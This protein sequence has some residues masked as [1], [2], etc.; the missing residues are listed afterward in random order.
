MSIIVEYSIPASKFLLGRALK[1]APDLEIEL[2]QVIPTGGSAIPYFWVLDD[3]RDQ[4]EA[5]LDREPG[6]SEYEAVD[7]LDDQTLYRAEWD[8]TADTFVRVI[9]DHDV[10]LQQSSGDADSWEFQ[11]RFPDAETLSSFR[12]AYRE[13][14]VDATVE[15]LYHSAE[16]SDSLAPLTE[17]QRT[18]LE[19]AYEAGYFEVPRQITLDELASRM[20][21]SDQAVNE[22]LRRGLHALLGSTLEPTTAEKE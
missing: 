6:L 8:L 11:L 1:A 5:A 13:A 9:V 19:R 4:F 16:Y 14:D 12:D 22:R 17:A 18:V 21:L 15:R 3:N 2:E 7:E 20:D 10:V